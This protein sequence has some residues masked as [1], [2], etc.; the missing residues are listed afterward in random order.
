MLRN[1]AAN[2]GYSK[3]TAGPIQTSLTVFN[4]YTVYMMKRYTLVLPSFVN[5]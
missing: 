4:M 2:N 3:G 1:W 5:L